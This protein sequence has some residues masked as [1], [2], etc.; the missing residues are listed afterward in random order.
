MKKHNYPAMQAVLDMSAPFESKDAGIYLNE[1]Q[2][3]IIEDALASKDQQIVDLTQSEKDA[4][5][6]L[7]LET[8]KITDAA[9]ANQ[10]LIDGV[11]A[12][13]ELT[14]DNKVTTVKDALQA[15]ADKIAVLNKA[16]GATH[17]GKPAANPDDEIPTHGVTDF[18]SSIYEPLQ[19]N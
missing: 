6:A 17:S 12:A 18:A 2:P 3:Q 11:N 10:T 9:T 15:Q 4:K 7:V 5:D 14:G 8:K 13:L 16:P 1:G 19:N